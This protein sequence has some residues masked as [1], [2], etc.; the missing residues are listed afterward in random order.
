[1]KKIAILLL[2]AFGTLSYANAQ[3]P[4]MMYTTTSLTKTS[5]QM[6]EEV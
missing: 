5:A 4:D 1:M 6:C 3:E 2:L